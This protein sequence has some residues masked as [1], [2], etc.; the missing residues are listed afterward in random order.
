MKFKIEVSKIKLSDGTIVKKGRTH[1]LK[2]TLA[3]F[4]NDLYSED[5]W[6]NPQNVNYSG[7]AYQVLYRD[8]HWDDTILFYVDTNNEFL[9]NTFFY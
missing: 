2:I 5:L 3:Q 1:K 8:K 7:E 4:I 9:N 6:N